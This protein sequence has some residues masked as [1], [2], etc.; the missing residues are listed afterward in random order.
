MT[1]P[2]NFTIR[3]DNCLINRAT[4]EDVFYV[5]QNFY[6]KMNNKCLG[7]NLTDIIIETINKNK[8]ESYIKILSTCNC[9]ERHRTNFPKQINV[10]HVWKYTVSEYCASFRLQN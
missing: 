8:A 10:K 6:E 5:F 3:S 7:E 2:P 4:L 9:C 1:K